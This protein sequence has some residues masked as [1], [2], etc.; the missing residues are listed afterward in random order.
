MTIKLNLTEKCYL[1]ALFGD[2]PRHRQVD[3][4]K[5]GKLPVQAGPAVFAAG[6]DFRDGL[7]DAVPTPRRRRRR[8]HPLLCETN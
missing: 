4:F 7:R 5:I 6:Y 8:A 1:V 3:L 2:V